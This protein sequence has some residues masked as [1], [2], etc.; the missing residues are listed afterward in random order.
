MQKQI[1]KY[2]NEPIAYYLHK[3]RNFF[4]KLHQRK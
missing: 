3:K 4:E 1:E 2:S